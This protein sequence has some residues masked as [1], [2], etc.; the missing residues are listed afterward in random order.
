MLAGTI[1]KLPTTMHTPTKAS[2]RIQELFRKIAQDR[3][4]CPEVKQE[5]V[6][7]SSA[8]GDYVSFTLYHNIPAGEWYL[9]G[10]PGDD[11]SNT[12]EVYTTLDAGLQG[13]KDAVKQEREEA[14]AFLESITR[15]P[16]SY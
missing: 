2:L 4:N 14:A 8:H 1:P 9:F 12:V 7:G 16:I 11:R 13:M 3:V 15:K 6:F 10:I 5:T